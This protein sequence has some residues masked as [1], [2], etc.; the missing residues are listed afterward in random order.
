MVTTKCWPR[1]SPQSS[2]IIKLIQSTH[3]PS[4]LITVMYLSVQKN[5]CSW[6]DW[7]K[8]WIWHSGWQIRFYHSSLCVCWKRGR[9]VSLLETLWGKNKAGSSCCWDSCLVQRVRINFLIFDS[10]SISVQAYGSWSC[11]VAKLSFWTASKHSSLQTQRR[12]WCFK[13]TNH[14]LNNS[15]LFLPEPFVPLWETSSRI[16]DLFFLFC[17]R[18]LLYDHSCLSWPSSKGVLFC[19]PPEKVFLANRLASQKD[20]GQIHLKLQKCWLLLKFVFMPCSKKLRVANW[21]NL[22]YQFRSIG[23]HWR[24]VWRESQVMSKRI[25][26]ID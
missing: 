10:L 16:W 18:N 17:L 3:K 11:P 1:P 8:N 7:P 9:F 25:K 20:P 23:M 24:T 5:A 12:H 26:R 2:K 22:V 13:R 14:F 4:Q 19:S 15:L 21:F 6:K